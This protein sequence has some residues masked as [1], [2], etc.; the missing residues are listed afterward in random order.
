MI[1]YIGIDI[2]GT[3]IRVGALDENLSLSFFKKEPTIQNAEDLYCKITEL[4]KQI[5]GFE[6]AKAIGIGCPGVIDTENG[7]ALT[8]GHAEMLVN[9]PL[10]Q[11]LSKDFSKPVFMENDAKVATLAEAIVGSGKDKR[12]VCYVTVS[13]GLGGGIVVDRKIYSGFS[14][15]GGYFS[16]MILDGSNRSD[17]LISGTALIRIAKEKFNLSLNSSYELFEL[18]QAG[19]LNAIEIVDDFKKYLTVLLL[20]I[21]STFNP[22]IIVLGGGVMESQDLFLDDV[23]NSFKNSAHPFA[24]D[25][26]ICPTYLK[27][28]GVIGAALLAKNNLQNIEQKH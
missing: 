14:H 24:V 25:T 13:T 7:I 23:I 15:L 20:N 3:N 21:S 2:G 4:I 11:R 9:F 26:I 16:R 27:E 5:P 22:D 12:I 10:V 28:P 8:G 1:E 6:T 18:A 19:N 17:D